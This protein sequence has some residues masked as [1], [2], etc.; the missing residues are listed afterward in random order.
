MMQLLCLVFG[1][2]GLGAAQVAMQQCH[3]LPF[4]NAYDFSA[5][6]TWLVAATLLFFM[7]L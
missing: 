5:A 1:D 7:V 6:T 2:V 4:N 3:A